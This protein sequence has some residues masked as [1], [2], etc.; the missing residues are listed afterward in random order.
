MD[1]QRIQNIADTLQHAADSRISIPP[2]SAT[3]AP[4]TLEEA[5]AVQLYNVERGK[6]N[7]RIVSGKKVGLTN[8]AMQELLGVDQPD[9]G[10]LFS[11]M[12]ITDGVLKIDLMLQPRVEAEIAFVLKKDLDSDG[13]I[14]IE[15]VLD[16]TDYVVPSLEIVDSRVKDWKIGISDT[17]ADNAS[18]GRY[19][20]GSKKTPINGFD[21]LSERMD[22]YV[23][24]EL[25]GSGDG[26]AV[27]G[28]SAYCV[29]WLAQKMGQLGSGLKKGDVVLPGALS[30][31]VAVSE[32]DTVTARF[33][34]IGEVSLL[35]K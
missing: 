34:T 25:V 20:L 14:S 24:D 10:H 15:D 2:L 17:V 23:N 11:D 35:V 1:T 8:K 3:Y 13:T 18:C 12:E 5:Y 26:R 21:R 33:S 9:Y 19:I 31:M 30:K 16:A 22:L 7:G 28:D 4:F 29:A 27:L 6:Q 32:G